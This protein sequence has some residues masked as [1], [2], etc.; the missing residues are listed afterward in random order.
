M[1]V[2]KSRISPRQLINQ[3]RAIS[4]PGEVK[5]PATVAITKFIGALGA[6][7]PV[8][9]AS[10]NR[11]NRICR[12]SGAAYAAEV[13]KLIAARNRQNSPYGAQWP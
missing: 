4:L 11:Q 2:A 6:L 13:L 12:H 10:V 9:P 7:K 8:S 3:R 1:H 5:I